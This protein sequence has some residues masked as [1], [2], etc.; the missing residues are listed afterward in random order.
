MPSSL[1]T[2]IFLGDSK[3]IH[4]MS[5][6]TILWFF[7]GSSFISSSPS[8]L[9]C[10]PLLPDMGGDKSIS[11][12]EIKNETVDL[13]TPLSFSLI[14]SRENYVSKDLICFSFKRTEC[15]LCFGVLLPCGLF[16]FCYFNFFLLILSDFDFVSNGKLENH[17]NFLKIFFGKPKESVLGR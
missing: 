14:F 5:V 7:S 9:Y 13:V 10:V 11:L 4:W 8:L 16:S 2:L 1:S 6:S 3:L 12:E 17:F 15:F